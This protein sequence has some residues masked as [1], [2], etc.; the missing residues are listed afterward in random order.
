MVKVNIPLNFKLQNSILEFVKLC[1]E[2]HKSKTWYNISADL[3]SIFMASTR[4][5]CLNFGILNVCLDFD[6]LYLNFSKLYFQVYD[7]IDSD[8]CKVSNKSITFTYTAGC[9][10]G[11]LVEEYKLKKDVNSLKLAHNIS[12]SVM[13]HLTKE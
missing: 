10:I 4:V 13:K 1:S 11:G 2:Q 3:I 6:S 7:G 5:Y 9:F 12:Q 8:T